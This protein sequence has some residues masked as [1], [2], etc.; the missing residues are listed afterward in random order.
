MKQQ[1]RDLLF[2][3]WKVSVDSLR[4][5]IPEELEIDTYDGDAYIAL[6]PFDMKGVTARFCP[7]PSLLCD[8]PEFNVRTYVT[9]D[10]KPGVWF[11]SLDITS[12]LAVWAAN[13]LF[14]LDYRKAKIDLK[15]NESSI[16]YRSVYSNS[17][18]FEATYSGKEPFTATPG[19]FAQW[20]TERY[21]L[22]TQSNKGTLYRGEIQHP[23]WILYS[24]EVEL[25]ENTM[26]DRFDLINVA[27]SQ[28]HALYSPE[29]D[30]VVYPL[31]K[32]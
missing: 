8:F 31:E 7:A 6:V 32:L 28:P 22:Y 27:N 10:G 12:N 5:H 21:C 9:L 1:W 18:A 19:S 15:R 20:A 16:S 13:N 4:P 23:K 2:L 25:T 26:L 17:E 3:H 11:F 30:V 29:I 24:A 14:H